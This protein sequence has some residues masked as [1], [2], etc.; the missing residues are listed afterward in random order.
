MLLFEDFKRAV[1]EIDNDYWKRAQ[2]NR[3]KFRTSQPSQ[4]H[5]PKLP[6]SELTRAPGAE[7]RTSYTKRISRCPV[8]PGNLPPIPPQRS[9]IS[10]FLGVD[11][12]LTPVERQRRMS[13]GLCLCCGQSG[14]LARACPKQPLRPSNSLGARA[15]QLEL[16]LSLSE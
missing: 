5:A 4:Y 2:D 11:G 12:R 1:L 9:S 16:Y 13:L 15:A 10:D 3:N 6:R 7:E 14:H 8:S